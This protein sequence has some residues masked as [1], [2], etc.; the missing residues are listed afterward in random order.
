MM[1]AVFS[2]RPGR[3]IVWGA[4]AK[5]AASA[6]SLV[7]PAPAAL[8]VVD[9]VGSIAIAA[10]GLYLVGKGAMVLQRR[11]L[12]RVRRK[13]IIS[14]IFV[15]VVPAI[16]I[17]A[18]FLLG[19]L[20]LFANFSSYLLQ[21]RLEALSTE[22]GS[23]ATAAA[24]E[25]ERAGGRDMAAI[26]ARRARQVAAAYPDASL[27]LVRMDG[28]CR[29][30]GSGGAPEPAG[31]PRTKS[32][33]GDPG[34]RPVIAGPWRHV[35]PPDHVPAWVGC[36]G[37]RGT[38]A[39]GPD[40]ASTRAPGEP[41]GPAGV[42]VPGPSVGREVRLL[43]R[44]VA[45]PD[46]PSAAYAV[47]VDLPVSG[48]V[49]DRLRRDTGVELA[50][51]RTVSDAA[52]VVPARG[53]AQVRPADEDRAGAPVSS[54]S[55]PPIVDWGTGEPRAG[56]VYAS[57][58]IGIAEMY[59]RIS[60]AQ[61]AIANRS[62]GQGLLLVL[63]AIG[64]LF[65][66][67]EALALV[68]GLALARS[69]TG[70]IHAL[71]A[72]T[73]RVRHGDFTHKIAVRAHDQLGE[74]AESFNSMTGSIERLLREE[75]E[76]KRLEEELRIADEIQMSLLPQGPLGIPGLSVTALSVPAREVGGD[77]YDVFTLAEGMVGILI[78]DVSGKGTSAALYMAE[79]KGLMLSLSRIHT[80]P[81]ALLVA[82]N[83]IIAEHLDAR[84]F[85]TMTYA[86]VDLGARTLTYARA[87]HT[88]LMYL[89][90]GGAGGQLRVLAPDGLVVGL[91]LDAGSL[92]ED[93]RHEE[94][95][96][97]EANGLLLLF[98]DGITEAMNG[99]DECFG[100]HRL[101]ML[102]QEHGHLPTEELRERVL[103]EVEAFVGGAPQHDDMTL[104]LLRIGDRLER[105]ASPELPAATGVGAPS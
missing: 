99:A 83:R 82:A 24:I 13:L 15:G 44:A 34:A 4:A 93:L 81:R 27:A 85:I 73:E 70:S 19:G 102:L 64:L 31:P 17:A 84:S 56:V 72:G 57:M 94:A 35:A 74:L 33:A 45:F 61:G 55:F 23:I 88:P 68:I 105:T 50:S 11:L 76:K 91:K 100:E 46:G 79:L 87:G 47:V 9:T 6:W 37:F 75:A 25:I 51:V 12:W 43:A 92:F 21:A 10:G 59:N 2:T 3:A 42:L 66:G 89:P 86:V 104:L 103:R 5:L 63:A 7:L 90:A 98:T 20:L 41:A 96:S 40:R 1:H 78:A 22:A 36:S 32:S 65:L 30:A 39:Y 29:A 54:A 26:L 77:Y 60:A 71:F 58:Q 52:P 16:L 49:T 69:I 28:P 62:F 38:L 14:Y 67:I 101:A 53:P 80:S 95:M 18:F 8:T 97:I 48:P